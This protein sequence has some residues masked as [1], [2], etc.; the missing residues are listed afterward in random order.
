[1]SPGPSSKF[2]RLALT[3]AAM[4]GGEASMVVALA[5][6]FFFD[7]DPN[8]ARGKVLLFL[9]V[10]FAPFLLIAPLVG[11]VIDRIRG[12]RRFVIQLVATSRIV[13]Q[14]LMVQYADNLALF[15]L[16]FVAL[17]LQKTYLVSK[18]AIVPSVVRTEE[19]LVE[20]NSK[21]GLIA[22]I[23][24]VAAVVPAGLLQLAL[25]TPATLSYGAVLFAVALVAATRLPRDVV[26]HRP[27]HHPPDAPLPAELNLAAGAMLM[28]RACVGFLLF[29]LAFW[30]REQDAGTAWFGLAVSLAALGTTLGNAT[31]PRLRSFMREDRMIVLALAM[32]TAAGIVGAIAGGRVAGIVLAL[33]VNF[34]AAV[35]RLAFESLVQRDAPIAN[36]GHTFAR[37][38]TRFQLGWVV[39]GTVPVLVAIPGALGFLIVGL[40]AGTALL[41]YRSGLGP[42]AMRAALG[43]RPAT[44]PISRP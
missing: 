11:P 37:F 39:A 42:R 23:T 8:A 9:L 6:S 2:Q 14:L 40:L 17:V 35:G 13:V 16:V 1:V 29:Q 25:G 38:E 33:V 10:S 44:R 36:R 41:N 26:D 12:G 27:A 24:G 34:A 3:H 30:F 5:D 20:A 21:L 15:P 19:E 43:R 18:S 31:G 32:P 4:M 7:V 28:L 22:A